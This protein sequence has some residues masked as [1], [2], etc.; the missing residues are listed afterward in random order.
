MSALDP[1]RIASIRAKAAQA[2]CIASLGIELLDFSPGA[3]RLSARRDPAFDGVQPGFHGGMLAMVSDCAAW[4]AIVTQTGPDERLLTTD[5]SVKYLNPCLTDAIVS[6]RVIK[7]GRTLCPVQVELS[8][9][10][11]RLA[12]TAI[13]TYIRVNSL[14]SAG[15]SAGR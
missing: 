5:L 14:G 3:C 1:Q 9:R 4:C 7:L 10:D 6:A 2:P 12:A 13:V 15:V 11:G 8:D